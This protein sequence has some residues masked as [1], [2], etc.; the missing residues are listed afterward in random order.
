[1]TTA[2]V[3]G[4]RT[5]VGFELTRR[6]LSEGWEVVALVRSDL[7]PEPFVKEAQGEQRLRVVKGDLSDLGSLKQA[8][9]EITAREASLDVLFNNAAISTE[10]LR[11]SP[12]GRELQFEVNTVVPYILAM[13]LKDLLRKGKL[14]TVINSSSNAAL[15]VKRFDPATLERPPTFKKL[16]GPYAA[17]KLA[18][19]LWTREAASRFSAEGIEIRSTCPGPNR[20]PMSAGGGMP[21]WL[22]PFQRLTFSHPSKGAA[23]LHEVAFGR[24]RGEAGVFVNRGKVTPLGFEAEGRAVLERVRAVHE[25][26]FLAA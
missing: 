12:G 15:T 4:A 23:R 6:L 26:A 25:G 20:T 17:S 9:R 19:S 18:L 1:M 11:F 5:G 13:E 14:R 7:P 3:T 2:L 16:F 21:W 8:L 10:A 22:L 24:F